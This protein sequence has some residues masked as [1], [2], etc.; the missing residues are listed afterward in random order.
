[1]SNDF[2][3]WKMLETFDNPRWLAMPRISL[4]VS[5]M[6]SNWN[7]LSLDENVSATHVLPSTSARNLLDRRSTPNGLPKRLPQT[8]TAHF[9]NE[10]PVSSVA[11]N[12]LA[13][14]PR[15]DPALS[16]IELQN[17][18]KIHKST[19]IHFWNI[20]KHLETPW[21]TLKHFNRHR[22]PCR[23][24]RKRSTWNA[25][26][27]TRTARTC[28]CSRSRWKCFTRSPTSPCFM[29]CWRT[30][31]QIWLKRMLHPKYVN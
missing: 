26:S 24:P 25:T 4:M 13:R 19:L 3:C 6:C 18:T 31:N 2:K 14:P 7:R 23:R 16:I 9:Q 27:A 5:S 30:R 1:M 29:I 10:P 12:A 21:N 11:L 17:Q 28:C 20:F 22:T 8:A 15:N